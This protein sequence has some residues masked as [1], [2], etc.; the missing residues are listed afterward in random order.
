MGIH[1]GLVLRSPGH[2]HHP[3]EN[4]LSASSKQQFSSIANL[5]TEA[6]TVS[7]LENNTTVYKLLETQDIYVSTINAK[8]GYR[9]LSS[10]FLFIYPPKKKKENYY[11]E[12][13]EPWK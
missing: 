12:S 13:T 2:Q 11:S 5:G 1:E 4:H 9:F 8:W 6:A 3:S 10:M 7:T